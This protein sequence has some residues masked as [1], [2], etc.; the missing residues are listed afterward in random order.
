MVPSTL[1]RFSARRRTLFTA[2][3]LGLTV[4]ALVTRAAALV[5]YQE[6]TSD[7]PLTR[8]MIGADGSYQVAYRNDAAFEFYPPQVTPGDAATFLVVDHELFAPDFSMHP[9]SAVRPER[10]DNLNR[11]YTPFT[12]VSQSTGIGTGTI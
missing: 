10:S 1:R 8:I 9:D 7:G 6:I 3:L 12:P 2:L 11:P 5:A 4:A